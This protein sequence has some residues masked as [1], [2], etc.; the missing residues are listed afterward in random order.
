MLLIKLQTSNIESL[1]R[2]SALANRGMSMGYE[3]GSAKDENTQ[4]ILKDSN[5]TITI[6]GAYRHSNHP[7]SGQIKKFLIEYFINCFTFMCRAKVIRNLS[8]YFL[9]CKNLKSMMYQKMD[10][11]PVSS[12]H[13]FRIFAYEGTESLNHNWVFIKKSMKIYGKF[14]AQKIANKY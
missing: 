11:K 2:Q 10:F 8:F 13:Q 12:T 5:E 4:D 3:N 14:N 7:F 1:E 6:S 9:R